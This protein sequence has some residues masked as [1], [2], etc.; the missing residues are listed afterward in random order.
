MTADAFAEARGINS[1][2][3]RGWKLRIKHK[4]RQEDGMTKEEGMVEKIRQMK[5]QVTGYEQQQFEALARAQAQAQALIKQAHE[6]AQALIRQAQHDHT[7]SVQAMREFGLTAPDRSQQLQLLP[8]GAAV[9]TN[10][11]KQDATVRMTQCLISRGCVPEVP[12]AAHVYGKTDARAVRNVRRLMLELTKRKEAGYKRTTEKGPSKFL[13]WL[14]P[15][16]VARWR[17]TQED[18]A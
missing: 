5:A 8:S 14:E 9:T 10:K 7:E 1:N 3:L 17:T 11:R 4:G 16:G 18:A 6:Q 12:L 13:F 15:A 2:T